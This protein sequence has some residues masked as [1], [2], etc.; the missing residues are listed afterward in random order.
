MD[1]DSFELI[2]SARGQRGQAL[3]SQRREKQRMVAPVNAGPSTIPPFVPASYVVQEDFSDEGDTTLRAPPS[4]DLLWPDGPPQ[5]CLPL[6]WVADPLP[7]HATMQPG[8]PQPQLFTTS[9]QPMDTLQH[10][11]ENRGRSKLPSPEMLQDFTVP[12]QGTSASQ[13]SRSWLPPTSGALSV[14]YHPRLLVL[15]IKLELVLRARDLNK[16]L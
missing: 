14:C 8:L 16:Q 11:Q 5:S 13:P 7:P 4:N 2:M 10:H 9:G 15:D 3:A 6:D 1:S 12:F